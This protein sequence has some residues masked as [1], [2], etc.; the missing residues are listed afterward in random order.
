MTTLDDLLDR[1]DALATS[2]R[3]VGDYESGDIRLAADIRAHIDA[4]E[5]ASTPVGYVVECVDPTRWVEAAPE[6][7]VD[8]GDGAGDTSGWIYDN[9]VD[10]QDR[11]SLMSAPGITRTVMALVPL[12]Y[13]QVT[14]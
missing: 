14:A 1:V 8:E 2:A 11:V 9:H 10:A 3:R 6:R 13:V 4:L 7:W 5:A 12:E